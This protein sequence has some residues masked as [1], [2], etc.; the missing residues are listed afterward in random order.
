MTALDAKAHQIPEVL[1]GIDFDSFGD[2]ASR[3]KC[4]DAAKALIRRLETPMETMWD[5]TYNYPALYSSLKAGL[6]HDIY[7]KLDEDGG[8]PKSSEQLVGYGP[9]KSGD[10]MLLRRFLRHLK[11]MNVL[12][13]A[14]PDQWV[15]T[16]HTRSLRQPEIFAAVNYASDVSV[17]AFM[18]LPAFLRQ[19]GYQEPQSQLSGNWQYLTGSREKHF[20]YLARHP[21][22]QQTFSN[23]MMGYASQRGSWLEIFPSESLLDGDCNEAPLLVDIGGAMGHDAAKFLQK[24]PQAAGRLVFQ[25]Q[26]QVVEA[27]T[28]RAPIYGLKPMVHDFFTPQPVQGARAYFM[29]NI[30]HDWPADEGR[31][32]LRNLKSAMKP[33]YSRL[34]I[35][36]IIIPPKDAQAYQTSVDLM[37]MSLFS[38]RE[39]SEHDWSIF[40]KSAG[41]RVVKFWHSWAA[42]EGVI[43]ADLDS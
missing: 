10:P 21:S 28:Q 8:K 27:A 2:A 40:L 26:K 34:L 37:M 23:L 5:V 33:G 39:R 20:D 36:E 29:H 15:P 41:F 25:D 3:R 32:I 11:A 14:G 9:D 22:Q 35:N 6:D 31:D 18:A 30:L 42:F 43:E 13:E 4:L 19:I 7:Q 1:N 16:R 17:K 12:E 38:S 24:H